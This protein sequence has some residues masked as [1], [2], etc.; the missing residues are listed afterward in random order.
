MNS[1]DKGFFKK[2]GWE[3]VLKEEL[4]RNFKSLADYGQETYLI[5]QI[6]VYGY[7]WKILL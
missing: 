3:R 1:L 7:T 2:K 6:T 4:R 5:P